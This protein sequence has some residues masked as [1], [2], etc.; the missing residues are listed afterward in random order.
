MQYA[1]WLPALLVLSA[2]ALAPQAQAIGVLD[3]P[4]TSVPPQISGSGVVGGTLTCTTS[5]SDWGGSPNSFT[6]QWYRNGTLVQDSSASTYVVVGTD[7]GQQITCRATGNY[8]SPSASFQSPASN[9]IVPT[10]GTGGGSGDGSGNDLPALPGGPSVVEFPS[11]KAR[12]KSRR[13]FR[14]RIKQ[15]A[16]VTYKSAQVFVNG[17]KVKVVSA[18]RLTAPVDLR[19]LPAGTFKVKI[20]VTTSDDR[21]ISAQRKYKTCASKRGKGKRRKL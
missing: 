4:G 17:K 9:S 12:C 3:P 1:R 2:I 19:G 15:A 14:I 13:K 16:G 5:P 8:T 20:T 21:T 18:A 11:E 10:G 7:A 6:Y